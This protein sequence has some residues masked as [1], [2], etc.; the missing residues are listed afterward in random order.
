MATPMIRDRRVREAYDV[1]A[2][3][4]AGLE[5]YLHRSTRERAPVEPTWT[6]SKGETMRIADMPTKYLVNVA[7][8]LHTH[9]LGRFGTHGGLAR[10]ITR[11]LQERGE[12]AA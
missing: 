4:I 8:L 1:L 10:A 6:N 3:E 5:G 9:G 2:R 7:N 12:Q 11:E